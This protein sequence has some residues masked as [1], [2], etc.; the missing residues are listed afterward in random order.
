MRIA[1]PILLG[2]AIPLMAQE[3]VRLRVD[4]TDAP[5]RIFHVRMTIPAKPGPM[6]LLYPEWIPGEHAPTGPIVNLIGLKIQSG[7]AVIP[8]KRDSVNLYA[9]HL[10]VPAGTTALDVSF[11]YISSAEPDGFTAGATTTSELAVLNW[12]LVLLYPRTTGADTILYQATLQVP[13]GW[14]YGTALPIARESGNEVEFR[15]APLDTL[16]DSPVSAGAH[17]RTIDLGTEDGIPHFLNVAAD[18][19]RAL[20]AGP[21]T[22]GHYKSLVKEAGALF[23]SR[24]YRDYHFLFTLSD[25]VP[26]MGLEHH[27][28]SDDRYKER[29][30]IDPELQ[31][32]FADLLPHEFVHSW[33]GKYRRPGGLVANGKEGGYEQPMKGDLLWVYEGLTQYLGTILARRS[34]LWNDEDFREQLASNAAEMDNRFGRRWRPL[35]DTAV[36][37]QLLYPAGDDYQNYRRDVDYYVEGTLIWLDADV[38]IRQL[39]RGARSLDDFCRTFEGGP[40][41]VP[42]LKTYEFEDIVAAL[43][44]VQPYDWARFLNDRIHSTAAQAPLGGI[45]GGGWKLAYDGVRSAFWKAV[46]EDARREPAVDLTYSIGLRAKQDGTVL[47]VRYGGPAQKAGVAPAM[48]LIAVNGR[49][50]NP[51]VLR[52]AVA[53]TASEQKPLQLLVKTGE[54]YETHAVDYRGGERYPHLVRD[55]SK[56]D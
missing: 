37:A 12:N 47:D 4:A 41:G 26:S 8:W 27:E 28:S 11:D 6:T 55:S 44:A 19:D 2:L 21:E 45:E 5:R 46:E 31:R 1:I 14:R 56:P 39:S 50:F 49:Q 16:I 3:M 9:F 23:G 20:E 25:H 43:N 33:N 48:K 18:S 22:I 32:A 53:R 52:E 54:F 42:A 30:L 17:Y 13:P 36:A 15:P 24:H 51:T 40:G 34:G 38:L 35:E 10:D 7:G 29:G